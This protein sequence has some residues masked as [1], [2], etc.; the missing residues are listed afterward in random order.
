MPQVRFELHR[1]FG[2]SDWLRYCHIQVDWH[3]MKIVVISCSEIRVVDVKVTR[4]PK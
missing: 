4:V 1:D 3:F 2:P